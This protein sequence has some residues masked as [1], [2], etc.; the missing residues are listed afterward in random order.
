MF[1]SFSGAAIIGVVLYFTTF[2]YRMGEFPAML[3]L[4]A[5]ELIFLGA[6]G[7]FLKKATSAGR[8]NLADSIWC[9]GKNKKAWGPAKKEKA[10]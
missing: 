5:L 6:I 2:K 7:L 4:I 8:R 10:I 9:Y 1:I 3:V